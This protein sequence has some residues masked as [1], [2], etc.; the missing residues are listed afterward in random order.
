[1]IKNK[2]VLIVESND[3]NRS[4]FEKL[5]CKLYSFES[6]R[7]GMD[8][9]DRASKEKFDLILMDIHMPIMDGITASK[10]IKRQSTYQC[11]I[12]AVAA[13][14]TESDKNRFLE[15][16]FEDCIT[17]P[18]QPKK[19]LEIISAIIPPKKESR[20]LTLDKNVLR[21]LMK[22]N[23]LEKLKSIY[24]DFLVEFDQLITQIDNAF[25]EKDQFSLNEN[26]HIMK[27]NSGT[28]GADAIFTMSS[29]AD[30]S[31]SSQDWGSL[32]SALIKLKHER[33]MFEKYLTEETFNQ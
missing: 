26:L 15:L 24:F 31:A 6:V 20:C 3:L 11:P 22:Y 4:L 9:V 7:N 10:I 16:G 33:V 13:D 25:K 29:E 32:E 27:G 18:I 28:L 17:K 23:S 1:M 8:A 12:I 5:I 19:F 30:I 2:K 14:S 21:Q